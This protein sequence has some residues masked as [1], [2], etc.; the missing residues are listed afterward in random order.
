MRR[1]TLPTRLLWF[2]LAAI[3]LASC[4]KP[5]PE[6]VTEPPVVTIS[7]PIEREVGD[8]TDFT[9]QTAAVESVE[10]RARVTGYLN[11][12]TFLEG[13]EVKK[14]DVLFEIDP[15]PYQAE[16]DKQEG[17]IKLAQARYRLAQADY[18]RARDLLRTPG[19]ISR[20]EIETYAAKAAE[21]Q[22]SLDA[23]KAAAESARLNVEFCTVTAPIS[24]L[25]GRAMLTAGNLVSQDSSLLTTI[26][27]QDPIYA[28]VDIDERTLLRV[29]ELIREGKFTP[30]VVKGKEPVLDTVSTAG[31]LAAPQGCAPLTAALALPPGK[32][33]SVVPL[34]LELATE[35]GFPH[36]GRINF[37]NNQVDPSTGT[38]RIR[39]IFA[40]SDRVL[41]PGLFVRVRVPIGPAAKALLVSERA[42]GTSQGQKY[43]YVLDDKDE[44]V[45]RRV[46]LGP[47]R[48]GLRV[49]TEGITRDDRVIV[50]GL[51]RVRPGVKV[52]P[53]EGEMLASEALH[54]KSGKPASK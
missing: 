18:D 23:A 34:R 11:R 44:V 32:Q 14:G 42:L 47:V 13:A 43:V 21:S 7:K 49:L 48:N 8:Y 30:D 50:N 46:K 41:T 1:F 17:Q 35:K 51:L 3:G 31:L 26:V 25:V 2:C 24:G 33:Y 28:Y 27:A 9:G 19:A 6:V 16:L 4:A 20:Q 15:R 45:Y 36:H 5:P 52:T 54:D 39:G 37:V 12:I 29:R 40:N 10:V 53:K 38:I 22:A